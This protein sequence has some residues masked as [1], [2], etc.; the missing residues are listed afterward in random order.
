[1]G[2]VHGEE[3]APLINGIEK[4]VF[5]T[6]LSEPLSWS[7]A[8]LAT[9]GLG[10]TVA[11]LKRQ[12]GGDIVIVGGAAFARAAVRERLVDEYHLV[13][14][15]VAIGDGLAPFGADTRLRLVGHRAYPSGVLRLTYQ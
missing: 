15:P 7:N 11:G 14:H 10:S 1:M 6:T 9:Q 2:V 13:V 4:I 5:S 3:I 12:P 8:R